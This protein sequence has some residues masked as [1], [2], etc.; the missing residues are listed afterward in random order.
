MIAVLARDQGGNFLA[1]SPVDL[2]GKP[3]IGIIDLNTAEARFAACAASR[4][5]LPN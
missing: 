3:G 2:D 4:S 5:P 1:V